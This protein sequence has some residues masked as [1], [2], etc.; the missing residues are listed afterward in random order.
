MNAH[1]T[2]TWRVA[3]I[4]S[5]GPNLLRPTRGSF[6]VAWM[7]SARRRKRLIQEQRGAGQERNLWNCL[8]FRASVPFRRET[9]AYDGGKSRVRCSD[10]P[11][12]DKLP[13]L[14]ILTDHYTWVRDPLTSWGTQKASWVA[15]FLAWWAVQKE[16][17]VGLLNRSCPEALGLV[18]ND[19][20]Q[21]FP[22]MRRENNCMRS[23]GFHL[24][25][26][27]DI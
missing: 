11:W 13:Y 12:F 18:V 24:F 26:Y 16:S 9:A 4:V 2:N 1:V 10:N 23:R 27:L 15:P 3:A 17:R 19:F 8:A 6:L 7:K 14:Q 5:V 22:L 25:T 20:A 21:C